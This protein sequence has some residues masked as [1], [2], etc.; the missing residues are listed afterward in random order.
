M[1][2]ED[3]WRNVLS[4]FPADSA[5]VLRSRLQASLT[6]DELLRMELLLGVN[7]GRDLTNEDSAELDH[8][9]N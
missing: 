3:E 2:R 8:L 4:R 5:D 7:R 1:S 9:Q 6:A